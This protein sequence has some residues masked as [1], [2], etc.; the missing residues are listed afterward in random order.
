MTVPKF[1]FDGNEWFGVVDSPTCWFDLLASYP[2]DEGLVS[3]LDAK[4]APSLEVQEL[5]RNYFLGARPVHDGTI[6]SF[7][8]RRAESLA[9]R[10]CVDEATPELIQWPL[11]VCGVGDEIVV[12]AIIPARET[13]GDDDAGEVFEMLLLGELGALP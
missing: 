9:L 5:P 7:G 6:P 13:R 3:V 8:F 1:Y 4:M 12:H 2:A 11:R 10:P